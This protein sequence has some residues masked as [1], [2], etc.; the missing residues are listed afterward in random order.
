MPNETSQMIDELAKKLGPGHESAPVIAALAA[1]WA[2]MAARLAIAEGKLSVAG[3]I[4]AA[5]LQNLGAEMQR[6]ESDCRA[7][8]SELADLHKQIGA[9]MERASQ[10]ASEANATMKQVLQTYKDFNGNVSSLK[11]SVASL[12]KTA[13]NSMAPGSS[14]LVGSSIDKILGV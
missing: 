3:G 7:A 12:A 8:D 1:A 6:L 10:L 11:S 5:S 4:A 13:L 14:A 2:E 9:K